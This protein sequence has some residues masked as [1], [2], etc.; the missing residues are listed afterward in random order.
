MVGGPLKTLLRHFWAV[1]VG[2]PI[3]VKTKGIV[4]LDHRLLVSEKLPTDMSCL[5]LKSGLQIF[6]DYKTI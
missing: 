2:Q 5:Y 4:A 3:L 1:K 6:H